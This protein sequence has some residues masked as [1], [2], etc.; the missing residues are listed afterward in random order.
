MNYA[1][2]FANIPGLSNCAK[3]SIH[4][5][6]GMHRISISLAKN[7]WKICNYWQKKYRRSGLRKDGHGGSVR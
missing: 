3:I 4:E 5:K 2:W 6:V 1:Y 7:R